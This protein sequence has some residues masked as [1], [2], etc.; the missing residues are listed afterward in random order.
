MKEEKR[1]KVKMD[2]LKEGILT[3]SLTE[4]DGNMKRIIGTDEW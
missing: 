1:R 2:T 4:T 3:R